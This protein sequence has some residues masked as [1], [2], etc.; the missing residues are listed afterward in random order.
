MPVTQERM[1]PSSLVVPM[2]NS[3][4]P[5]VVGPKLTI[6]ASSYLLSLLSTSLTKGPP[7]SPTHG[8]WPDFLEETHRT[9][10]EMFL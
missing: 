2:G 4:F 3:A 1:A 5:H 9:L 6:P 10:E 7:E 8:D